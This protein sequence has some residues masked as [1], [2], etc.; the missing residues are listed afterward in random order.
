VKLKLLIGILLFLIALNLATIGTF[1]YKQW[2]HSAPH[3]QQEKS[4]QIRRSERMRSLDPEKR[5]VLRR[6]LEEFHEETGDLRD[7]IGR[8]EIEAFA[9]LEREVVPRDSLDMV[10]EQLSG[11]RLAISR[12]ATDKLIEAK[13]HLDPRQQK[14]F[15]RMIL[16]SRPGHDPGM[17]EQRPGG[18]PRG[19][20]Q[21]GRG[22]RI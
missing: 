13:I 11:L 17:F 9:L 15:F 12:R 14:M 18:P 19:R 16:M 6:L 21:N 5:Q 1:L 2:K 20:D 10:L 4:S 22:G 3:P 8:M 7:E